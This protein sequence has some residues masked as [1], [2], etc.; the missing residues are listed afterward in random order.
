MYSLRTMYPVPDSCVLRHDPL[1]TL[2]LMN[3]TTTPPT[4]QTVS[5][6]VVGKHRSF[7]HEII[8]PNF[9]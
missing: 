9:P 2:E 7:A 3:L 6:L 4:A 1:R 8:A 5:N